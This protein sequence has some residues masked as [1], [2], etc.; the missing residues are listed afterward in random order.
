MLGENQLAANLVG[1]PLNSRDGGA[2]VVSCR[3]VIASRPL[4]LASSR[5]VGRCYGVR[6][7]NHRPPYK[8]DHA[9]KSLDHRRRPPD[10]AGNP[11]NSG[12]NLRQRQ[13]AQRDGHN[14]G[15]R[16]FFLES[17]RRVLVLPGMLIPK[18]YVMHESPKRPKKKRKK[19]HP[20][21]PVRLP[22]NSKPYQPF[23]CYAL[24]LPQKG[25]KR[26]RFFR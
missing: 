6:K 11:V 3:D 20:A 23:F 18:E 13:K 7:C 19:M 14:P 15:R 26:Q 4:A 25:G 9:A 10:V 8:L 24:T 22:K 16:L 1:P 17:F 21:Q 5:F 2:E 12:R